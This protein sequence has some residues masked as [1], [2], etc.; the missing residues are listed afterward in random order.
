MIGEM[1]QK[2]N[3]RAFGPLELELFWKISGSIVS[4]RYLK[5]ILQLIVTMTAET[6]GSKIC[7]ILLLD[8]KTQELAVAA[9]Q[10][11]SPD[12]LKKPNI[13]VS[14]SVSGRAVT[15]MHPVTV[16][17][18]TREKAFRFPD[19]A[20][21]EKIV[22]LLCVPMMVGKR[23]IGVIN[24]Y[25]TEPRTFS[26]SEIKL[27]QAVANQAAVAIENT[28]LRDEAI[29]AR[30]AVE[31]GKLMNR[32]KAA[33]MKQMGLTEDAA[34]QLLL[35][36]SRNNRKTL[37]EVAEAVLLTFGSNNNGKHPKLH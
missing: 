32:A 15:Q 5:E 6:L 37:R 22:S 8:E 9:T 29:A 3:G 27:L 12:Y 31:T 36:S 7:S 35:K 4:G 19:I 10:S 1:E 2:T 25:T 23:V 24:V 18:V 13:K 26:E 16:P 11:I 21:R 30:D 17:D 14:E 33:L 28:K 20:R 34:H